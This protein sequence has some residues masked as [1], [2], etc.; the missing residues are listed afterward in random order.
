[1]SVR[2]AAQLYKA[3]R[4]EPPRRAKRVNVKLP[5]S[6][7]VMGTLDAVLYT[8][9]IAGKA[10]RFKHTFAK[11]SKPLLCAGPGRNSLVLVG[12]RYKVTYRGIVDLTPRGR[13]IDD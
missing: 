11:G 10:T 6:V 2:K 8:T 4:E 7:M 9:T 12:G 13:E 1:V 5:R 3:F